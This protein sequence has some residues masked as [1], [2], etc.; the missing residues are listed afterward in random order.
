MDFNNVLHLV[1]KFRAHR[2]LVTAS[3][4]LLSGCGDFTPQETARVNLDAGPIFNNCAPSAFIDRSA[5][6]ADRTVSFGGQ[7]GSPPFN[8][9]PRCV[10]I[11][12][13][14]SL[15]FT[16]LF[17]VHPLTPGS[18]PSNRTTGSPGN[19][20]TETTSGTTAMFTFTT[21]GTY[22]FFCAQHFN[23]GMMGA[24]LVQ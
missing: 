10:R 19:P 14:Q 13:G 12:A 4:A 1:H 24:V 8:Y 16:G 17:S 20:I 9:A 23:A 7:N 15:T 11:A 3:L 6:A 2:A 18:N 22:P 21:P 5:A